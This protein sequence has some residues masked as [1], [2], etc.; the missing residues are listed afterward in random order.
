[1]SKYTAGPLTVS[2]WPQWPFYIDTHDN[3]GQLVFRRDMPMS[4]TKQ[5]TVVE[6][7]AG[8]YMGKYA[9]E[10]FEINAR[11]LADEVLRAAAPE[12]REALQDLLEMLP[13]FGVP[14]S[15]PKR[16]AAEAA[17]AKAIGTA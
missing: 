3:F 2:V 13:Q 15:D 10:A 5:G 14:L 4:S 9:S 7:M 12:L 8:A 16:R 11:A 1:M 6:V 17:I